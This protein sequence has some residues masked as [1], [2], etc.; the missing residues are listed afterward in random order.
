MKISAK[1]EYYGT[2]E[3]EQNLGGIFVSEYD[4]IMPKTDWHYHEN[5][6]FMY[7]LQGDVRDFNKQQRRNCPSGTLIFH[8]W[9]EAHYNTKESKTAR[10]FH[11][12]F[13]RKWFTDRKIDI[14]LWEGTQIIENPGIH[15][16]M[17]K[18]YSEFRCY[19]HLSALSIELLLFEICENI[20]L[21]RQSKSQKIPSWIND[22]KEIL[23]HKQE[24][25]SLKYL[26]DQLGVHPGHISRAIPKYFSSTLGNYIRQQKIKKAL[27]LIHNSNH[28]LQDITFTC[29]FSDQSHFIR[30]F[31]SFMG[32][33][34]NQYKSRIKR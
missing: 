23:H 10:G 22:L 29:G 13:E 14:D 17:A 18:L 6:Y 32:M 21:I 4:Y 25:L 27:K 5:P 15:H 20:E 11:I 24:G 28:T 16:I 30:T 26:S 7:V 33:T 9:Q 1:G 12:E 3:M 2:M 8:N 19:D 34:P 31:K